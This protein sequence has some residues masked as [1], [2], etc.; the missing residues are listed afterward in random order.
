MIPPHYDYIVCGA[1]SAGCLLANRLSADPR[2]H[3][4]LLEAGGND[5][6]PWIHIPVGYLFCIGNPRATGVAFHTGRAGNRAST[7]ALARC[8][9]VLCAGAVGTPQLLQLSGIGE[10]SLLHAH[11]ICIVQPLLGVGENL[12]DRLQIRAVLPGRR[13]EDAQHH[14]AHASRQ[15]G[16]RP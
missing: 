4:L 3:V 1:G 13:R 10:P 2:K 12:Q 5:R 8:E 11:G 15:G 9:V 14:G 6:Y 16:D 7:T